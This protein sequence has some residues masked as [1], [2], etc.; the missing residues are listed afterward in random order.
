MANTPVCMTKLKRMLQLLASGN[1]QRDVC[2]ILHMGRN[3]LSTYMKRAQAT[4]QDYKTL[5]ELS[6]VDLSNLLKSSR[7]SSKEDVRKTKELSDYL[8][9]AC[10]ELQRSRHL[11][12][13][14]LHQEYMQSH[15][16]GYGYT[17]FKKHI[18]TYQKK[19][20]YSYHNVYVPGEEMQ[21]DFAGDPLYLT[22]PKTKEH[23]AVVVLCCILPF[24]G[25]SY[26]IALP[27]A[28]LEHFFWGLSQCYDY[29]GGVPITNRSDNMKQWVKRTDRYEPTFNDAALEWSTYYN[30]E[31]L[32]TRVAHP[33]DKGCVE[34]LVN[35]SY[36]AIYG[37]IRNEEFH[38]LNELNNRIF[39]LMDGYN[40]KK[41]GNRESRREVFETQER[42]CLQPLPPTP[43]RFTYRKQVRLG[44][45][46]HVIVGSERHFYSVPYQYVGEEV[47]VVWDYENVSVYARGERVA[48]HRRSFVPN[49]YTTE[50]IHMPEKH[51]A[52]KRAR[53]R[54]A[55][56]YL[57]KAS[58][59]GE[60][61]RIVVGRILDADRFP[62]CKY[63]SCEGVLSLEKKYGS[64]R[65]ESA[66]SLIK[67][68]PSVSYLM[69]KSILIRK[70]D[71]QVISESVSKSPKCTYV[72]GAKA[73]K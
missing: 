52:Y 27:T 72:R 37:V 53:E 30:T 66:S 28:S 69:L 22:N 41:R 11:S 23:T 44:S 39:E 54:N 47:N 51:Q 56:F 55:A 1:S 45:I 58:R 10:E 61:T 17:Q 13:L 6:D 59:I 15:P 33:R 36:H 2:G 43:F 4:G 16:D 48:V 49:G 35:Q 25:L 9:A 70:L 34:S 8:P 19:H 50:E 68:C 7:S 20:N 65:V 38:V 12:V 64:E 29:L 71:G 42:H 63:R 26:V 57:D 18:R 67:D 62:Q 60:S 46:Y 40:E 73:F 21:I 3:V 14:Q 24:S 31:L 5:S 32:A